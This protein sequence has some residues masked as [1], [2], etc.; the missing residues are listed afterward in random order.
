MQDIIFSIIIPTLNEQEYLPK[1]LHSLTLQSIKDFEVIVVDGVSDDA[2]I[3]AAEEFNNLLHLTILSTARRN[4]SYQ[5]NLGANRARGSYYIFLDADATVFPDFLQ[6]L[7]LYIQKNKDEALLMPWYESDNPQIGYKMA[8][9]IAHSISNVLQNMGVSHVLTCLMVV[10]KE[11]FN[12]LRGFD[13]KVVFGEDADLVGRA[14][15]HGNRVKLVT[16]AKVYIS[17]RRWEK[18]GAWHYGLKILSHWGH[19]LLHGKQTTKKFKY[20]MGGAQYKK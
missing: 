2:T 16:K 7:K 3:K 17:M 19:I 5:R 15:K 4:V 14:L 18:E 6:E 1:L 12:H 13:E 10:K 20:E 8:V 9:P 11:L